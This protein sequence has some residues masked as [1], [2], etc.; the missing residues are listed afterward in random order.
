[1]IP[2]VPQKNTPFYVAMSVICLAQ[3][4]PQLLMSPAATYHGWRRKH[5][6]VERQ[7]RQFCGRERQRIDDL[8]GIPVFEGAD[9]CYQRIISR[10]VYAGKESAQHNR[11]LSHVL[12]YLP[13]SPADLEAIEYGQCG[14]N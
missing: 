14:H 6:I 2:V 9:I 5:S 10:C 8:I 1:M 4:T 3:K 7:E 11:F 13:Y 12:L